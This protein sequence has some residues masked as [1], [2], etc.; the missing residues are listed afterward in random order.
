MLLPLLA[1]AAL[2]DGGTPDLE[3]AHAE[4]AHRL[5]AGIDAAHV[6][7]LPAGRHYPLL[8][9]AG[10]DAAEALRGLHAGEVAARIVAD[11]RWRAVLDRDAAERELEPALERLLADLEFRVR[12]EADLPAGF[13]APTPVLGIRLQAYPAYRMARTPMAGRD[14]R[15]FWRLFRHIQ[16][17]EIAMTA[18]VETSYGDDGFMAFLYDVPERGPLGTGGPVEVVDVPPAR[19]ASLGCRGV[20]TAAGIAEARASLERWLRERGLRPDGELRVLSYNSP[21]VPADERYFEVQ[22]PVRVRDV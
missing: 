14:G 19:Y 3:A 5:R 16:T 13:P 10:R 7:D 8:L 17:H 20:E 2:A 18:P 1:L 22:L 4:A 12:G 15:A 9:A 21:M 6:E 11:A